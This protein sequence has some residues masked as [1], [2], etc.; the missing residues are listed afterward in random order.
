MCTAICANIV[1]SAKDIIVGRA[2]FCNIFE[3][4]FGPNPIPKHRG[5]KKM[6]KRLILAVAIVVLLLSLAGCQT[7]AGMGR[8]ITWSAEATEG[9]IEGH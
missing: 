3:Y 8:D 6:L 2:V 5:H 9:L 7:V 4:C 1:G